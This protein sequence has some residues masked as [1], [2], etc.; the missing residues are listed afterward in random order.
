MNTELTRRGPSILK[1]MFPDFTKISS[2]II[3][4]DY[5]HRAHDHWAWIPP[6]AC[7]LGGV[8][9]AYLYIFTVEIHREPETLDNNGGTNNERIAMES[10]QVHKPNSNSKTAQVASGLSHGCCLAVVKLKSTGCVC[11]A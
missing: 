4:Y 7:S 10:S 5:A 9:G 2:N 6:I 1:A 11:I 8:T 3:T